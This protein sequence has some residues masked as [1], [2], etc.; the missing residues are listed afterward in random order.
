M[1]TYQNRKFETRELDLHDWSL[2]TVSTT[3]LGDLLF[4]DEIGYPSKEAEVIDENIFFFVAEN[5]INL[6]DKELA[7]VVLKS[8]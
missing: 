2:V 1:I 7:K 6:S 3:S 8:L 4:N 5:E